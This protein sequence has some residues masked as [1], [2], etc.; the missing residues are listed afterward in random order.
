MTSTDVE[1]DT[2]SAGDWVLPARFRSCVQTNER[3]TKREH[4][5]EV[6]A[7]LAMPVRTTSHELKLAFTLANRA[8]VI[9][10]RSRVGLLQELRNDELGHHCHYC[11]HCHLNLVSLAT[12]HTA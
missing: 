2:P 9:R 6:L 1:A 4:R 5:D 8:L 3:D 10:L 7:N 11:H 12:V